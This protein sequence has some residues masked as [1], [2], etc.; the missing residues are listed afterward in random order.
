MLIL[1]DHE[2]NCQFPNCVNVLYYVRWYHWQKL[3]SGNLGLLCIIFAAPHVSI[4]SK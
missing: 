3:S 1:S 4:L 2:N